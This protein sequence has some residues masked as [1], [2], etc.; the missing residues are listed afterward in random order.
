[1]VQ[2]KHVLA[3]EWEILSQISNYLCECTIVFFNHIGGVDFGISYDV[4]Y[5][6]PFPVVFDTGQSQQ[7]MLGP[8]TYV[9]PENYGTL[10]TSDATHG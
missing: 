10:V 3:A 8:R 9:Q 2:N 1:M 5:R 7:N 4:R 6:R